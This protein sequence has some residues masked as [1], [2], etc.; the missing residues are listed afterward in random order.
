QGAEDGDVEQDIGEVF[1]GDDRAVD[2]DDEDLLA[3]ARD[4]LEDAAQVSRF[5]V[6]VFSSV[7]SVSDR[8]TDKYSVFGGIQLQF[9]ETSGNPGFLPRMN[10]NRNE[11]CSDVRFR[12]E[13][14]LNR[15]A[16]RD[17]QNPTRRTIL[18]R[19]D[20]CSF[21]VFKCAQPAWVSGS[22]HRVGQ[23]CDTESLE[24]QPA[25]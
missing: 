7:L 19:A 11:S 23:C 17:R 15:H 6:E 21:V 16:S 18:I 13:D 20:S 5:H 10:T 8:T 24:V 25:R 22:L 9:S 1:V 14:S 12:A 4:V 2:A 3:K